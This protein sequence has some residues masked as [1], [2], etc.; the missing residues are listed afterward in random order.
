MVCYEDFKKFYNFETI[1]DIKNRLEKE[2]KDLKKE[3]DDLKKQID[4]LKNKLKVKEHLK[5]EI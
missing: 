4:D 3:I 5:K 2:N 1:H